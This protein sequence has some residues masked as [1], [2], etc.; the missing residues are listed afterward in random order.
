MRPVCRAAR[1][2]KIDLKFTPP[3]VSFAHAQT[4]HLVVATKFFLSR[5][6]IFYCSKVFLSHKCFFYRISQSFLSHMLYFLSQVCIFSR[7]NVAQLCLFYLLGS[8]KVFF[9]AIAVA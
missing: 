5:E 8:S 7:S 6:G 9:V 4:S 3:H 1:V 2:E